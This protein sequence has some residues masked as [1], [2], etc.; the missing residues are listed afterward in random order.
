LVKKDEA[1]YS[2]G[3]TYYGTYLPKV[4]K[5]WVGLMDCSGSFI[6]KNKETSLADLNDSGRYSFEKIADLIESKPKELF[7]TKG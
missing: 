6:R 5:D 3:T 4:V 1:E 7:T 2:I